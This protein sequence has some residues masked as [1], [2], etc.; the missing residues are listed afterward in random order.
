MCD[1]IAFMIIFIFFIIIVI[2]LLYIY[3]IKKTLKYFDEILTEIESEGNNPKILLKGHDDFS[4]I[5]FKLNSIVYS[6]QKQIEELHVTLESNKQLMTSLSHDVRTPMTT[7]I[8]YLDAITMKLVEGE[9]KEE[10]LKQADAKA[11][12]LKNYIEALFDWFRLN[13]ND[14]IYCI[15]VIDIVEATRDILKDWILIWEE[16]R[17]EYEIDIPETCIKVEIDI[18][19]YHRIL[20]NII[21]NII[22]HSAADRIVITISAEQ[23]RFKLK[24]S[25]NGIGIDKEDIKYIFEKLYKCNKGRSDKGNG[26]GLNIVKLLTEKMQGS[27][28]AESEVNQGTVFIIEFPKKAN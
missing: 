6:Y 10:Y 16:R 12:D 25:D 8:G 24:I 27:V 23:D 19:C 1:K 4:L 5:G 14:E 3:R 15:E 7:L 13:S 9:K 21:Q 26:L 28:K 18:N 22:I 20:N 2:L 17:I 11:Y